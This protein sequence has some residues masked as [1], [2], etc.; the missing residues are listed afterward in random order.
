MCIMNMFCE[1]LLATLWQAFS[2]Y[3]VFGRRHCC[4]NLTGLWLS[5]YRLGC[6]FQVFDA[7]FLEITSLSEVVMAV[8][9]D[10]VIVEVSFLFRPVVPVSCFV[11]PGRVKQMRSCHETGSRHVCL[12]VGLVLLVSSSMLGSRQV[13]REKS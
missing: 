4:F 6:F 8:F 11:G 10:V 3:V 7:M 5:D 13:A 2:V 9:I 12:K 1:I